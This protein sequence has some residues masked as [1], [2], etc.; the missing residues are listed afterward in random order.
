MKPKT[1][2]MYLLGLFCIFIVIIPI[3]IFFSMGYRLNSQFRLVKTGGIYLV[4]NESDV[5]VKLDGENVERAGMFG[6]NIL[7]RN[8]IPKAYSMRVEKEGFRPWK[9]NVTVKEEKVEVCYPLLIPLVL[10]PQI[11][12]K[13]V[14]LKD[15][16]NKREPN[17]EYTEAMNLFKTYDKP[18]KGIIPGWE[19][20]VV[21]KFKLGT[22]RRLKKKVLL[23]REGNNIY[24]QWTGSDAKRPF[25]IDSS[26]K[27]LIFSSRK[28]IISFGFFPERNNSMLILLEDRNLFA[29]EI[30]TRSKH[31]NIYKIV[32]NCRKFAVMDEYLYY[33]SGSVLYRIDFEP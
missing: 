6:N 32:A 29:V 4:N 13:Y 16:K 12:S 20:S 5:T 18:E 24:V 2:K 7:I 26:E 1:R 15:K 8:L 3:L 17:E 31:Q 11:V 27:K 21:K 10:K 9:K 25:F 22:N 19:D 14:T 28:K 33:F 23:S 30:D